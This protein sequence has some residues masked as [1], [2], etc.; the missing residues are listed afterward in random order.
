MR[1]L[2]LTALAG[3]TLLLSGCSSGTP[4]VVLPE[5]SFNFGDVPVVQDMHKDAK[6]HLFVIKNEGTANLRI[7]SANVRLLQGC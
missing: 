7:T 2:F 1:R 5:S 4:K 3:A 6:H